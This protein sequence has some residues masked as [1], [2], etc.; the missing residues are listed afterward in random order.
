MSDSH[1]R[2]QGPVSAP[3]EAP[4]VR[5]S[6]QEG[7]RVML[8]SRASLQGCSLEEGPQAPACSNRAHTRGAVCRRNLLGA[9]Q[10]RAQGHQAGWVSWA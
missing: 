6:R 4:Y 9:E 1:L 3:Q 5:N 8:Q 2:G 7:I 10:Q